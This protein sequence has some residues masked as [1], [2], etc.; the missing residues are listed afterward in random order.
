MRFA[1]PKCEKLLQDRM[2]PKIGSCSSAEFLDD[3]VFFILAVTSHQMVAYREKY[4]QVYCADLIGIGGI[5]MRSDYQSEVEFS[6]L[7]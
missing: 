4:C 7:R 1:H 5:S 6:L 2:D 3:N